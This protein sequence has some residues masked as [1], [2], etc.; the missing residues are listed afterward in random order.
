M[1]EMVASEYKLAM[2]S[3]RCKTQGNT[4]TAWTKSK[5]KQHEI[6]RDS[7]VNSPLVSS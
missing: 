5:T 6:M 1:S 2:L 7:N 4:L 3:V